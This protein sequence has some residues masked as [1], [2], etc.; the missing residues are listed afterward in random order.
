M[1]DRPFMEKL[2]RE[3]RRCAAVLSMTA[4]AAA[5]GALLLLRR[6]DI[7]YSS[8]LFVNKKRAAPGR[9][10]VRRECFRLSGTG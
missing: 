3:L 7:F 6:P 8:L 2:D 5:G 4:W 10:R 1:P 9:T